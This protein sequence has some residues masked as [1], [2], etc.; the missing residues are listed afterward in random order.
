[1]DGEYEL[2]FFSTTNHL[3]NVSAHNNVLGFTQTSELPASG[4]ITIPQGYYSP[5]EL[6]NAIDGLLV[7]QNAGFSCSFDILTG[8]LTITNSINNFSL[9]FTQCPNIFKLLG[10]S[11]ASTTPLAS[12]WTGD[13]PVN[14][15]PHDVMY[16]RLEQDEKRNFQGD[17]FFEQ[18]FLISTNTLFGDV[19]RVDN[20][21]NPKQNVR[22]RKTRNLWVLFFDKYGKE[23]VLNDWTLILKKLSD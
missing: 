23:L 14:L 6:N 12:S 17:E 8:K 13:L 3:Y 11:T 16:V 7:A 4:S 9:D 18:T 19:M 10:N 15:N 5:V 2:Y 22:L 21:N 20:Q 1:L